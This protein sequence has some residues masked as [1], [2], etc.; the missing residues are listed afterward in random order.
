[1]GITYESFKTRFP[2]LNTITVEI[3]NGAYAGAS[4]SITT[5]NFGT[6]ADEALNLITAH[7]VVMGGRSGNS[8]AINREKV[9]DLEVAY[10]DSGGTGDGYDSTSYGKSF[11]RLRMS[12]HKQPFIL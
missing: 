10:S 9:G 6:D 12:I 5:D 1:M 3:F 11:K 8:G 7:N 4:S 2:E